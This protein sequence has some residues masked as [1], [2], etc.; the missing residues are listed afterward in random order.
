MEKI[1]SSDFWLVP[2]IFVIDDG[3]SAL[4]YAPISGR[5]L[6][7]TP[8]AANCVRTIQIDSEPVAVHSDD[9][10]LA[11]LVD[12]GLLTPFPSS[13]FSEENL[14]ASTGHPNIA[15]D[16]TFAPIQVTLNITNRC[17]LRCIYCFA[18]TGNESSFV[19]MP[20]DCGHAAIDFLYES[21]REHSDLKN[22]SILFFG[23]AEPT[24]AWPLLVDLVNHA[25]NCSD[26]TGIAPNFGI[27]TNGYL[28]EVQRKFLAH[29]FNSITLSFDGPREIQDLH[30]PS[31][32]GR[33]S[34]K[35]VLDS[36]RFFSKYAGPGALQ[37][38]SVITAHSVYRLDEIIDFF[39]SELPG[40]SVTFTIV[41]EIGRAKVTGLSAPT[42]DVFLHEWLRVRERIKKNKLPFRW[43]ADIENPFQHGSVYCGAAVPNFNVDV[44]GKV[45]SCFSHSTKRFCYGYFDRRE[46]RFV[47]NKDLIVK[48]RALTPISSPLCRRCFAKYFCLGD[49]VA[50]RISPESDQDILEE[51]SEG[52][53]R[54][55]LIR[56]IVLANLKANFRPFSYERSAI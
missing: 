36:A 52:K 1:N 9:Q 6:R 3:D 29:H 21:M 48:L 25:L 46:H 23:E 13:P 17:P 14:W 24:S 54:C 22:A 55:D 49:C 53:G 34:F 33:S 11:S 27:T 8:A 35:R 47:F 28:T 16:G 41:E 32:G 31:I 15:P 4:L 20:L 43:P 5:L 45:V 38:T 39:L 30:R 7:I 56:G 26:L 10:F 18:S 12:L 40:I 42:A 2:D 50:L 51:Y 37:I 19:D 44:D